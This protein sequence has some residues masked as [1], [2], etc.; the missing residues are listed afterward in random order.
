MPF[1]SDAQRKWMFAAESRGEVPKGTA[2]QWAKHTKNIKSLP[3]KVTSKDRKK[4]LG[5]MMLKK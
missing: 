5:K 3:K 1:K 2:E 4:A